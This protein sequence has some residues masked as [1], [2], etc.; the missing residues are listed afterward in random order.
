MP[1][2]SQGG[3]GRLAK[4]LHT[5]LVNLT[6]PMDQRHQVGAPLLLQPLPDWSAKAGAA[7][8]EG[9]G[10]QKTTKRKKV[11]VKKVF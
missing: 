4:A 8:K 1:P 9:G 5:F 11:M 2:P 7:R 10:A 6:R 3:R